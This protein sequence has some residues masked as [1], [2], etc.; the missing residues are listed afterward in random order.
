M[1]SVDQPSVVIFYWSLLLIVPFL[2]NKLPRKTP[3]QKTPHSWMWIRYP[4]YSSAILIGIAFCVAGANAWDQSLIAK[5]IVVPLGVL[6]LVVHSGIIWART[7]KPYYV[8]GTVR[9]VLLCTYYQILTFILLYV[10]T[11]TLDN[12]HAC[13]TMYFALTLLALV[14]LARP[15]LLLYYRHVF[16]IKYFGHAT[17]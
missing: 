11:T 9:S 5:T 8:I 6:L 14:A 16:A 3:T 15:I 13:T 7:Q 10:W 12:K 2:M 4:I 1:T 17:D